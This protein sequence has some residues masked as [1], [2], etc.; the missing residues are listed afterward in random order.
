MYLLLALLPLAFGSRIVSSPP[1]FSYDPHE[2]HLS[3]PP[4]KFHMSFNVEVVV[5]NF[6]GSSFKDEFYVGSIPYSRDFIYLFDDAS[7]GSFDILYDPTSPHRSLV[8]SDNLYN[9]IGANIH[10]HSGFCDFWFNGDL[11][12]LSIQRS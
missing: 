7:F 4:V 11:I 12:S 8:V 1:I 2:V 10:C 6:T 9:L 3:I 5:R